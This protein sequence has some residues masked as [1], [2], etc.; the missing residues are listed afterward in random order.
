MWP[1]VLRHSYCTHLLKKNVSP[2]KVMQ[3]MGHGSVEMVMEVY[4]QL[5]PADAA[6]DVVRALTTE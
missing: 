6:N 2:A 3:L 5:Q 1:H 4:N